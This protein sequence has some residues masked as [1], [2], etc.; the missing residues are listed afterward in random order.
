[1]K[2][3][4]ILFCAMLISFLCF[5]FPD[6]IYAADK[7]VVKKTYNLTLAGQH[8]L[9]YLLTRCG[10]LIAKRAGEL[11]GGKIKIKH[12]AAGTLFKDKEIP[13]AVM[14]GGCSMGISTSSRWAGYVSGLH[15]WELPFLFT[16]KDQVE[17]VAKEVIPLFDK[18]LYKKGAKLLGF[19]FYGDADVIGNVKRPVINPTD[20][21]G[22]K[23]R[24][25]SV[26]VN[27]A[28]I[29]VG[30]AP[31]LMSSA[32]VYTSLQRNTIDGA[33]SG[34]TTFTAR[35]WMEVVRYI[36]VV[37][38]IISYPALP[39]TLAI[40][41]SLWDSM[42]PAAQKVMLQAAKEAWDYSRSEVQKDISK[43]L[44]ILKAQPKL[45]IT[46]IAFASEQWKKWR[47]AMYEPAKVR[48]LKLSGEMG[49][50]VLKIV[51]KYK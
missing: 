34:S 41:R 14:S 2:K 40:N 50:E 20:L 29:A 24:S 49:P 39:F 8:P 42:E 47:A 4:V 3:N 5:Q 38:G 36:T 51:D 21:K 19:V 9:G 11:S 30:G 22:L 45:Q 35:K 48:F 18:T 25:F 33:W 23:L 26:L 7:I 6:L 32:E 10:D 27:Q 17:N 15:F 46:E 28:L 12:F 13:A 43:A 16:N 1:M 44:K 37:R 31:V